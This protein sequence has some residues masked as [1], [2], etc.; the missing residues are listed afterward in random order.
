MILVGPPAKEPKVAPSP[1]LHMGEGT[2]LIWSTRALRA[3]FV[4][5]G[6]SKGNLQIQPEY[7][8]EVGCMEVSLPLYRLFGLELKGATF[9]MAFE[10]YCLRM[11]PTLKKTKPQTRDNEQEWEEGGGRKGGGE[12]NRLRE[13]LRDWDRKY[14]SKQASGRN[15][16]SNW[17]Q[18]RLKPDVLQNFTVYGSQ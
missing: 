9:L 1:T 16:L 15:N 17:I 11:K 10:R 14:K 6:T 2:C 18:P 8:H 12:T 4:D 13:R 5:I 3:C 7:L